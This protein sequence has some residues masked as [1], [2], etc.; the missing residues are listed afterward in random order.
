MALLYGWQSG[1][2]AIV[3]PAY[4]HSAHVA[5]QGCDWVTNLPMPEPFAFV[6]RDG[7]VLV[8]QGE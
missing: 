6:A 5:V 4:L 3:H 2:V 8:F 7:A 1:Y